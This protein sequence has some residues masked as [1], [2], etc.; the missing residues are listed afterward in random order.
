MAGWKI[1]APHPPHHLQWLLSLREVPGPDQTGTTLQRIDHELKAILNAKVISG[2]DALR[3]V[4]VSLVLIDH[5]RLTNYLF[6]NHPE[7]GSLGVMIFFVLSGFLITGIL[8][9]EYRATGAIS[10]TNFYRRRA[11]RI[12]PTFY[13]CWFLTTLVECLAHQFHWKTAVVS[14]FYLMDYG[15]ALAPERIQ[16]YLHMW[17]SWSLAIEEKF[18]LLWPLCLLFLLKRPR[19]IRIVVCFIL[20]QWAY[21]AALYL[22]FHVSW[23]YLY[24]AFDMRMDALL[25]G[26]LLAIL[27]ERDRTR[28]LL[29]ALLRRQW[30]SLLAPLALIS[31]VL[32]PANGK[33]LWLLTWS[34]QPL[35]VA[36]MLLQAAY[37]GAKNWTICKG[38]AARTT[39][40]LSYAL[41]LYHPLAGKIVY[42]LHMRH[43]G[44]FAA[45]LTL[46]MAT[47]SYAL[48]E[49]PF[50]RLR[51]RQKSALKLI[52]CQ[53][54]RLQPCHNPEANLY[55]DDVAEGTGPK[56]FQ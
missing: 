4:A 16:P 27:V 43:L 17:I 47:A 48:V 34:V 2:L 20:G 51:D 45:V 6:G 9:R 52:E 42:L 49:R 10:L 39:A 54:Q 15:R 31:V 40:H 1:Q 21:R 22:A 56:G 33:A 38:A 35:L 46:L 26:C 8:L 29:C 3:A 19:A 50:M 37:W 18:Y 32:A 11:Y 13:C 23:G 28:L 53:C 14:F 44:W 7:L 12:F 30:L 24:H 5:F 55:L 36:V 25:V 41:Y